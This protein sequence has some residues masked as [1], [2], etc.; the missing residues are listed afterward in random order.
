MVNDT[1]K[2]KL[3]DDTIKFKSVMKDNNGVKKIGDNFDDSRDLVE[4]LAAYD[5]SKNIL[6]KIKFKQYLRE[7]F[8]KDSSLVLMLDFLNDKGD[9]RL[10]FKIMGATDHWWEVAYQIKNENITK[11]VSEDNQELQNEDFVTLEEIN[12]SDSSITVKIDVK[13][14]K[15]YGWKEELPLYVQI[16]TAKGNQITDA[17]NDP[18]PYENANFIVGAM[19]INKFL[20]YANKGYKISCY[21]ID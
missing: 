15:D 6:L 4:Y 18:K 2:I 10:P 3:Y 5:E 1:I 16:I 14:L 11:E 13:K 17:F 20:D 12:P 7:A 21:Y 19:P 8:E 9:Y